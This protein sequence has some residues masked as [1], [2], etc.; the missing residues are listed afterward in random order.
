MKGVGGYVQVARAA[1][2]YK[3][4]HKSIYKVAKVPG[5]SRPSQG[6]HSWK[7]VGRAEVDGNCRWRSSRINNGNVYAR[8][9]GDEQREG[10]YEQSKAKLG[11]KIHARV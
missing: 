1:C 8:R 3:K 11:F 10:Q 6:I 2:E 9:C 4:P 7:M 5:C